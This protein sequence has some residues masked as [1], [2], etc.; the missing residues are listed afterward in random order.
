MAGGFGFLLGL[1]FG[2]LGLIVA[3]IV[4]T[5]DR[6]QPPPADFANMAD[7]IRNV[8]MRDDGD[9]KWVSVKRSSIERLRAALTTASE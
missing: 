9:P 1:F 2:P 6:D 4:A 5:R 3:A 7:A 8:E